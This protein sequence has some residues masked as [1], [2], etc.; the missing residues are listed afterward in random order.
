MLP[1]ATIRT[2][3]VGVYSGSRHPELAP[4]FLSYLASD[5]YNETV[6]SSGDGLPSSPSIALTEEYNKPEGRKN[7]W[8]FHKH[9]A[10]Y[11]NEMTIPLSISPYIL[12]AVMTRSTTDAYGSV[13]ANLR[14]PEQAAA[15][16]QSELD[17]ELQL[18]LR[19]RP[20]MQEE[21]AMW[22]E[23]Q[24]KID[25]LKAEGKKI[26]AEWVRNPFHQL[27][28]KKLGMLEEPAPQP[29]AAP[30]AEA[31]KAKE[32]GSATEAKPAATPAAADASAAAASAQ[33]AQPAGFLLAMA[34]N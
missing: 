27:Y 3:A 17:R 18:T 31:E 29:A 24:K 26:P 11:A 25:A 34:A 13:T 4:Y 28:Y 22:A 21:Y 15:I 20:E 19:E 8:D 9:F 30:A 5:L 14:T 10:N 32:Q 1:N 6:V 23:R 33:S 2:R 16:A 12:P 7:E